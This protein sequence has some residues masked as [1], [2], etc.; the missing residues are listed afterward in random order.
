K[1]KKLVLLLFVTM[2]T[3][4]SAQKMK[5][6]SGDFKFLKGEKELNLVM[7]YSNVK[8][9]KENMDETAYIQKREKDILDSEKDKTE[10]EKWKKIGSIPKAQLL[11]INFWRR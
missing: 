3:L 2:T 8:F 5:V 4:A 11:W 10:V 7:D 9:Y 6:T 1:I